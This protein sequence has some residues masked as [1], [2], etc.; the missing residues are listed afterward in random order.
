[1]TSVDDAPTQRFPIQH[2]S[3]DRRDGVAVPVLVVACHP[4]PNRL[5]EYALL[6]NLTYQREQALNR[7]QPEF[8]APH[9]SFGEGLAI[10]H[11]SRKPLALQGHPDGSV[12][13]SRHHYSAPVTVNS[14][15]LAD[16]VTLSAEQLRQGVHLQL[17]DCVLLLLKTVTHMPDV[18]PA[19]G[20]LGIS[21]SIDQV[22][23]R[24]EKVAGLCEP[25]LI[26]GATGTGKELVAQALY[27]TSQRVKAPFI[28]VNLAAL[29]PSLAVAEL[30]GAAKGAYTGAT[31]PRQGYF[32][33]ADGGTLFLDEVGEAS[34]EVQAMLLRVL[35]TGEILPVGATDV[36]KVDVRI[37]AATDADLEKMGATDAFKLP[38]LHRLSSYQIFL[39][40]LQERT[41]DIPGLLRHF[42]LEQW[43][44]LPA[45]R[46]S[47][48][49]L[50]V[51]LQS[52][53]IEPELVA[54]LLTCAWHG[55]VRQLRNLARQMVIDCRG[56][57][58]LRI[59]P[60]LATMLE[61]ESAQPDPAGKVVASGPV[62]RKPSQISNQ[63]LA[64]ALHDA[65]YEL[66]ACADA[67]GVSRASVYHLIDR[68][69]TLKNTAD[70][71]DDE[72]QQSYQQ[73][74]GNLETMM[75]DLQVSQLGLRR[76]LRAMGFTA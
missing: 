24:I 44:Q 9:A 43:R 63:Q 48:E 1:M 73:H 55:N 64:Q 13:I 67:L 47:R 25:V 37:I 49:T 46:E 34:P 17:S 7:H 53:W 70:L 27:A 51:N 15:P 18:Q 59:D 35:E 60:Q 61:D 38:L 76:R 3:T 66:Q 8:F 69:P 50:P 62:K 21:A 22:R 11:I 40:P 26:R 42:L 19:H 68:H 56:Q 39:N 45:D 28:S 36:I 57:S 5:G 14:E 54:R 31:Q 52:P 23:S 16:S 65:R 71:S 32:Q 29:Q 41:E 75:W 6:H 20:L 72:L 33:A 2:S 10:A 58:R 30:F 4:D 74:H 12:T